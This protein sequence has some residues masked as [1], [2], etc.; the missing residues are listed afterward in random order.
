MVTGTWSQSCGQSVT[1]ESAPQRLTVLTPG[2]WGPRAQDHTPHPG[3]NNLDYRSQPSQGRGPVPGKPRSSCDC[4]AGTGCWGLCGETQQCQEPRIWHRLGWRLAQPL[5]SLSRTVRGSTE[6]QGGSLCKA[7]QRLQQGPGPGKALEKSPRLGLC[8]PQVLTGL[9]DCTRIWTQKVRPGPSAPLQAR[10][11]WPTTGLA[12]VRLHLRSRPA[13]GPKPTAPQGPRTY[14]IG[15]CHTHGS[16]C[17][18]F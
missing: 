16:A 6:D 9:L 13:L 7:D 12:C 11:A 14:L 3:C 10:H 18:Y 17:F 1:L 5:P 4:D 2:P 8:H 15:F